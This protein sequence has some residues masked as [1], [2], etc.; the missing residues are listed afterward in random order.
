MK[1]IYALWAI[2]PFILFYTGSDGFKDL[3]T[4][5]VSEYQITDNNEKIFTRQ[6][7]LDDTRELL[8]YLENMHPDPYYYSGGKVVFHRRFQSILQTIPGEG[9]SKD[10]YITLIRPLI[11]S[12]SDGHTRI[13]SF[14]QFDSSSPGGLPCKLGSVEKDIYIKSVPSKKYKQLIGSRLLSVEGISV[15]KL[16]KRL[17]TYEGIEN[18][19]HG[20]TIM[21]FYLRIKPYLSDLLPEWKDQTQIS[22]EFLLANGDKKLVTFDLGNKIEEKYS[23]KSTKIDLP[24]TETSYF[25]YKFLDDDKKTVILKIDE[26]TEYREMFESNAMKRDIFET[27]KPI[28]EKYNGTAA[29]DDHKELLQGIPSAIEL[30]KKM[31][32]E[33]KEAGT[34]NL[35]VDL[36]KNGGGNSLMGDILTYFLYGQDALVIIIESSNQVK[37]YSKTYFEIYD[38]ISIEALNKEYS[39]IQNYQLTENDYDF[40]TEKYI[41]LFSLG[42]LDTLTGLGIKYQSCPSFFN[43]IKDGT[44]NSYYLPENVVVTSSHNTFSS[45]FTF[46][47]YI[48]SSGAII[49]GNTSGQSGNGFGN[50]NYVTLANTGIRLAITKDA[51][52][53]FPESRGE[54]KVLSPDYILTYDRLKEYDFDENAEVLLALDILKDL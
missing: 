43:E 40:T 39:K 41:R 23:V 21:R 2:I 24:D 16:M 14:Y 3:S 46:L 49:V 8:M 10:E 31:A 36:S 9:M 48:S 22:A 34:Q 27:L 15:N 12:I 25:N 45:A 38:N 50:L 32:T 52:I 17:Y 19:Y 28:Y 44:Y 37:K 42:V 6:E 7:L 47:R 5:R 54:R 1:T 33:M 20:L 53:V 4:M 13:E 51:Y 29:P 18:D 26:L 30:F 35:I 11:A